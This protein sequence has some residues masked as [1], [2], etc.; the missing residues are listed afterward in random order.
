MNENE[1]VWQKKKH[2]SEVRERCKVYRKNSSLFE[3][4]SCCL[5]FQNYRENGLWLREIKEKW[6]WDIQFFFSSFFVKWSC[7]FDT[8][9]WEDALILDLENS[10]VVPTRYRSSFAV[11]VST[12]YTTLRIKNRWMK[13][14]F[15]FEFINNFFLKIKKLFFKNHC[16]IKQNN[17]NQHFYHICKNVR[18]KNT[19]N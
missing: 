17:I 6:K 4:E 7:W 15:L 3:R 12:K 11:Y 1:R 14:F 18:L 10:Q 8:H 2:R 5:Y 16:S 19:I 13:P 9:F